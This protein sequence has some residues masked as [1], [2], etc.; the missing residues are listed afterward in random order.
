MSNNL[1]CYDWLVDGQPAQRGFA[2]LSDVSGSVQVGV[3]AE[4]AFL[5][6]NVFPLLLL[7]SMCPQT[8]Q[9]WLVYR[10]LHR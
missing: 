1:K 6:L 5:H 10:G 4:S 8:E 3:E 2:E 9:V 7:R